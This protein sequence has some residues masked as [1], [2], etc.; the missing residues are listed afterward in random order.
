[1]LTVPPNTIFATSSVLSSVTRRP[2]TM[3]GSRPS[4]LLTAFIWGPPPWITTTRMP[5]EWSRPS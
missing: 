3:T 4:S 2:A 1:M 5:N